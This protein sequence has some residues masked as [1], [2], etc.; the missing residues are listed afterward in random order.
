[1]HLLILA[2]MTVT[3]TLPTCA[4]AVDMG[5]E[6][7]GESGGSGGGD[8]GGDGGSGGSS[9][10]EVT[11][12]GGEGD[13]PE[14]GSGSGSSKESDVP[15][16]IIDPNVPIQKDDNDNNDDDIDPKQIIDC[17]KSGFNDGVAGIVNQATIRHC[18]VFITVGVGG[19]VGGWFNGCM[20]FKGGTSDSVEV[21]AKQLAAK[22]SG[23]TVQ[24]E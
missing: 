10:D 24:R 22:L 21:C 1:M 23:V 13:S 7:G 14:T 3:M 11:S 2:V 20:E 17:K 4:F 6:G 15:E 19:Y 18:D 16:E 9:E 5:G 8:M 12:D